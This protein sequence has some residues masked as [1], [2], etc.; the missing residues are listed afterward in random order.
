[1]EMHDVVTNSQKS[2]NML[3]KRAH[4]GIIWR[5]SIAFLSTENKHGSSNDNKVHKTD[6]RTT[7]GLVYHFFAFYKTKRFWINNFIY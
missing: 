2:I 5:A 4:Y 3:I 7:H 6:V 1:M